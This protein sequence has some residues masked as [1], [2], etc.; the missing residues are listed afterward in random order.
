M[1]Q[2]SAFVCH[3]GTIFLLTC[4]F[5]PA[6]QCHSISHP[7]VW[8]LQ[9]RNL[10]CQKEPAPVHFSLSI[11]SI[12]L[13]NAGLSAAPTHH[14]KWVALIS[15]TSICT[16]WSAWNRATLWLHWSL[17]HLTSWQLNVWKYNNP[18]SLIDFTNDTGANWSNY[19]NKKLFCSV[20]EINSK[21]FTIFMGKCFLGQCVSCGQHGSCRNAISGNLVPALPTIQPWLLT[22][23]T[24]IGCVRC[25]VC[26]ADS[27]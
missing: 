5:I 27:S 12:W 18:T 21:V 19:D 3:L 15:F 7:S 22:V 24:G 17:T 2:P 25:R 23:G 26:C 9:C 13:L 16:A 6:V 14:W 20:A 4:V 10:P 8:A 1:S 11:D